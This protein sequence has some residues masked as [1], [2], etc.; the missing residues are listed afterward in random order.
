MKPKIFT[1]VIGL[2]FLFF[3]ANA[4]K[5][6]GTL[7]F[8][9]G[10][11]KEGLVRLTNGEKV[12]FRPNKKAKATKYVFSELTEVRIMESSKPSIYVQILAKG[13]NGPR[14]V[15]EIVK[16]RVSLYHLETIGSSPMY[17]P[18]AG[19]P[20]GGSFT[21]FGTYNIKNLFVKREGENVA[22]HLGSDQLFTKNFKKAASEFFKD[23]EVLVSRI[24]QREYKKRDVKEIV[25]FY[26][27]KCDQQ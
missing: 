3:S 11:V 6:K 24:Q 10:S 27:N 1:I 18:N 21:T 4:Q 8:K 23:C 25:T 16:G 22:T 2:L 20:G 13:H 9:D 5:T 7:F 17:M 12:K 19:D 26:N 15:K 14:I